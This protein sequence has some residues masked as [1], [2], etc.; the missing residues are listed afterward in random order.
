VGGA[1]ELTRLSLEDVVA[2]GLHDTDARLT[3]CAGGW[4]SGLGLQ[5]TWDDRNN[6]NATSVKAPLRAPA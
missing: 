2:G 5:L 1:F 6:V 4:Q 3:G